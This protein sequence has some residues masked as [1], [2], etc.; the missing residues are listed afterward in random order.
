MMGKTHKAIGYTTT[1][2]LLFYTDIGIIPSLIGLIGC[3]AP[4]VDLKL[5]I[6]HRTVT[7]WLITSFLLYALI[8]IVSPNIAYAFFINYVLHIIADT[9][10]VEGCPLF[11]PFYNKRISLRI[12]RT[13]SFME[14]IVYYIILIIFVIVLYNILCNIFTR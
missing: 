10:T 6:R 14:K 11:A 12:M 8:S 13:N 3:T 4:D 9:L 7:H 2:I 5:R 1:L